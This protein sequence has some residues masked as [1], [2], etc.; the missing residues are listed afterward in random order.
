MS[1]NCFL[2]IRS[3]SVLESRSKQFS[4]TQYL[5]PCKEAVLQ[6]VYEGLDKDDVHTLAIEHTPRLNIT[7]NDTHAI[8]KIENTDFKSCQDL[9]YEIQCRA[10]DF[11]IY[12][13]DVN[14]TQS[15]VRVE[16]YQSMKCR[17]R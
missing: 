14:F 16:D 1:N 11:D 10:P 13:L 17:M 3:I 5:L 4:L 12:A 2:L 15:A 7:L 6:V 9:K 8:V